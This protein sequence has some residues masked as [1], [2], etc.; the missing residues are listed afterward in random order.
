MPISTLWH[1]LSF[2]RIR[3]DHGTK[4]TE[5]GVGFSPSFWLVLVSL[6]AMGTLFVTL[7]KLELTSKHAS[8]QLG[9]LKR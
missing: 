3:A 1:F 8:M 7:C 9:A 2:W 6:L 5:F 4:A